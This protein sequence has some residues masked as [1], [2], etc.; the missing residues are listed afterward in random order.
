MMKKKNKGLADSQ[1]GDFILNE[2]GTSVNNPWDASE[3]VSNNEDSFE[4]DIEEE[5]DDDDTREEDDEA[6]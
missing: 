1:D 2:S 4:E 6:R 3:S 5:E